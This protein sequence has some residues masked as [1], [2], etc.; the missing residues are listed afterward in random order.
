MLHFS[1]IVNFEA[2]YFLTV[3]NRGILPARQMLPVKRAS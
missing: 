1:S 3:E 2:L